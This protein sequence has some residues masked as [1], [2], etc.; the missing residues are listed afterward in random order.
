MTPIRIQ[1]RRQVQNQGQRQGQWQRSA[2]DDSFRVRVSLSASAL[3]LTPPLFL[4]PFL[5]PFLPLFTGAVHW[6][7]FLPLS[8]SLDS[9]ECLRIATNIA[10]PGHPVMLF[11]EDEH[12]V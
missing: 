10:L 8:L 12:F 9:P 1:G 3:L 5:S 11:S 6:S 4:S 2:T 7:R